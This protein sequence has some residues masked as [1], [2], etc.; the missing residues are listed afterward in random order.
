MSVPRKE[1]L[2]VVDLLSQTGYLIFKVKGNPAPEFR[3]YKGVSEIFEGGRYKVVT[4]G[5]TNTVYFCI[6]KAKSTDEG[7]YKVVAYNKLGEDTVGMSLF[8]SD[9]NAVDFRTMLKHK[10]YSKRELEKSAPEWGELKKDEDKNRDAK[11]ADTFIKPLIN[12][13]V[14]EGKDKQAQFEAVFCKSGVKAK[15]FKGKQ[16]LF[17]GKKYHMSST[18]DLH[19]LE[20]MNPVED[21]RGK[22]TIQ[23]LDT[24]CSALLEVEEAEPVYTFVKKLPSKVEEHIMKEVVLECTTSSH[25]A[26]VKWFKESQRIESSDKFLIESDLLGRH[27]LKIQNTTTEDS[28]EYTCQINSEE[29]T[30]TKVNITEPKFTFTKLLNS[31]KATEKDTV[32]L[33]CEVDE[34]EAQVTWFK[35][36]TEIKK[37]KRIDITVEGHKR[38]LTIKGAKVVDKGEYICKTNADKTTGELIVEP[39]NKI[40]KNLKDKSVLER[41]QVIL[42]VEMLDTKSPLEW[43]KDGE[44]V[45]PTD[46]NTRYKKVQCKE[47]LFFLTGETAPKIEL[48]KFDF[49]GDSTKPLTIEVP[50]TIAGTRTSDVNAKFLRGDKS[51]SNKECDISVRQDL[52]VFTLKKTSR[53]TSGDYQIQISND[54]GEDKCKININITDIPQPP[55]GPLE[56][57]D[58]FKDRCKLLWKLPKDIGGLPLVHYIVE[59]QVVGT[60]IGWTEIATVEETKLDVTDLI[61]KKEYKFRVRAVNK[62]GASDPLVTPE[63]TLAKDPFDEPGKPENL[64]ITNWDKDN[65][66]LKWTAPEKD[67]GSP[68][69]GYVVEY[70]DKFSKNWNKALEVPANQLYGKIE[71][72]SEGVQYEFRVHAVNNAG[73]GDPSDPTKPLIVKA[74]FVKPYIIGDELINI[75]MKRGQ[76]VKYEIHF[77][78]DPSPEVVWQLNDSE[79]RPFHRISIENTNKN[80]IIVVKDSTRADSGKYKLTLTN[81]SGSVSSIAEVT[82]IDKPTPPEGPLKIEEVC[83][84][85]VKLKWKKPKDTGGQD[86]KEYLIEKMDTDTGRWIPAGEVGPEKTDFKVEGLTPKK[87]YRFRIKAVNKEGE[88][89]PLE[90]DEPVVA[91]NPY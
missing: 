45:K 12:I 56:V 19:V 5:N 58:V 7:R 54:Q 18:G 82:I 90:G 41:E 51:V 33:E 8:V 44:L 85:H 30:S 71:S 77:D 79:T 46:S 75:T 3:F 66:D 40:T 6:V 76:P 84:D 64:E 37:D 28:G 13:Q 43:F 4:D 14:K 61:E 15:W 36:E 78:G 29:R 89:E 1:V 21:D 68:I 26:R 32:M 83:A 91:K 38:C 53:G 24:S 23:C 2:D 63:A 86:L 70:R 35:G 34:L 65:V 17:L 55:E 62:K 16:E 47:N 27:T 22:Y 52:A 87:K 48:N 31:V 60:R 81:T 72:L 20:V 80:T 69:T 42:E 59:H 73:P 25:K 88:S 11:K 49:I 74:R 10:Q 39:A 9:E 57:F 50:F 67:G